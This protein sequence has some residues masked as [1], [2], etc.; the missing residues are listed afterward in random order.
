MA[1]DLEA[2]AALG[3][4]TGLVE[5]ANHHVAAQSESGT[6]RRRLNQGLSPPVLPPSFWPRVVD[7]PSRVATMG[8]ERRDGDV[9]EEQ[10]TGEETGKGG[11]SVVEQ[12]NP[13]FP[14]DGRGRYRSAG[15]GK[16]EFLA[17]M[18]AGK[19]RARRARIS[20]A[21]AQQKKEQSS[22]HPQRQSQPKQKQEEG[23][24]GEEG[25]EQAERRQQEQERRAEPQP[26]SQSP[27]QMQRAQVSQVPMLVDLTAEQQ[28]QMTP[29][30]VKY[31][32]QTQK[33]YEQTQKY[34]QEMQSLPL[35]Q[36]Q[37]AMWRLQVH[38]GAHQSYQPQ[39]PPR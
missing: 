33:Y 28:A 21:A 8:P 25:E 39:P 9:R 1:A 2:A 12:L 23:G 36:Q 14:R 10:V 5:A 38:L 31:Y 4:L 17:R 26:Q 22:S 6:K 16:A 15:A 37:Q 24:G 11:R 18:R 27:L 20:G 30:E 7:E 34:Y 13:P 19:E 3:A 29:A 35:E 32:E